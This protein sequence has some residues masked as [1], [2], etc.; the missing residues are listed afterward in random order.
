MGLR[1]EYP[2]RLSG[3]LASLSTELFASA[4]LVRFSTTASAGNTNVLAML[5]VAA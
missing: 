2:R 5:P 1:P 3:L 4:E